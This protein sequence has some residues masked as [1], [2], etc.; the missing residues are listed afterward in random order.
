VP[1]KKYYVDLRGNFKESEIILEVNSI[2]VIRR[3]VITGAKGM[4]EIIPGR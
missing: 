2:R 4:N 3:K 1:F